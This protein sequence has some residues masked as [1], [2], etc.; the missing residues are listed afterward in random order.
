MGQFCLFD[1]FL[2]SSCDSLLPNKVCGRLVHKALFKAAVWH[3]CKFML[4]A[5]AYISALCTLK[6]IAF[7]PRLNFIRSMP[8]GKFKKGGIVA[9]RVV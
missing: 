5:S 4:T 2:I 8:K 1:Y 3:F 9:T 7:N 6:F